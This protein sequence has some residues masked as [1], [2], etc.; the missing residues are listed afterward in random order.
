MRI[1]R[2]DE[3]EAR[4][5]HRLADTLAGRRGEPDLQRARDEF[6][7][8]PIGAPPIDYDVRSI[9]DSRPVNGFD[10]NIVESGDI[11]GGEPGGVLVEM[12]VP[13]GYVAVLRSISMWF[14]PNPQSAPNRSN[15]LASL[16]LN[17]GPFNYN[18]DLPVGVEIDTVPFFMIADEFNRIGWAVTL[19]DDPVD[20]VT[21][22]VHFHGNLILKSGRPA[23]FEV[24]NPVRK[25]LLQPAKIVRPTS[26]A[27]L[28]APRA[29]IFYTAPQKKAPK[30]REAPTPQP[31]RQSAT[32]AAQVQPRPP[33]P[34][35]PPQPPPRPKFSFAR[36]GKFRR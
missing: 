24:A 15:V 1:I 2:F 17:G 25:Q 35:P 8:S 31:Q 3:V 6:E 19:P 29:P 7:R 23:V 36:S 21:C 22:Y 27:Q 5:R 9:F 28:P 16:Y 30:A 34:T 20:D 32:P 13:E 4:H 11:G 12:T 33:Q 26:P 10:F 14:E 18:V